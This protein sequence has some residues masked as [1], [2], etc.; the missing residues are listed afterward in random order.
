MSNP[1]IQMTAS[2]LANTVIVL[3]SMEA[4]TTATNL[5][6]RTFFIMKATLGTSMTTQKV[7]VTTS[8]RKRRRRGLVISSQKWSGLC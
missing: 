3:I 7:M 8:V 6:K 4:A 2:K 1:A 5:M